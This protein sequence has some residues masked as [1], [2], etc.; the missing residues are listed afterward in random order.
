M[1]CHVLD[2]WLA[3]FFFFPPAYSANSKVD[4]RAQEYILAY[5]FVCLIELTVYHL[6]FWQ[7]KSFVYHK[8]AKV[9]PASYLVGEIF[10]GVL[11]YA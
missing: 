1:Y 6:V 11:V 7:S 8:T 5:I 10:D 3:A 9:C 4:S 2:F